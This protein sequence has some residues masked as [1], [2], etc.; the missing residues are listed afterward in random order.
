MVHVA[1]LT[2]PR[3]STP[4]CDCFNVA[5]SVTVK[6]Y[7]IDDDLTLLGITPVAPIS[8]YRISPAMI[9][10]SRNLLKYWRNPQHYICSSCKR[11]ISQSTPVLSGHSKWAT[12]KRDKA[13]NDMSRGKQRAMHAKEITDSSRRMKMSMPFAGQVTL[14]NE[15]SSRRSGPNL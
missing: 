3:I 8:N 13:R 6:L 9:P 1:H 10:A 4:T 11:H 2:F 7:S 5:A 15:N 12:I 14:T